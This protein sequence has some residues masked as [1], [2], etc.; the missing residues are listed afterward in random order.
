MHE[1]ILS[2]I[3]GTIDLFKSS[4]HSQL[5]VLQ[6]VTPILTEFLRNSKRDT[7]G[8]PSNQ[9]CD[10]LSH[11][12]KLC[13]APYIGSPPD[14]PLYSPLSG[15]DPLSFSPSLPLCIGKATYRADLLLKKPAPSDFCRKDFN[16]HPSL[17][18]GIFT[19]FCHHGVCYGFQVMETC[20]SPRHPFQ[21]F[22]SRFPATPKVIIY[23]N[24]CKLHQYCLN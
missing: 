11:I 8:R 7:A 23:D 5:L 9:V 3:G 14:Q 6:E 1:A 13:R 22:R 15:N 20:E 21:I 10:V 19:V 18:P 12:V 24:A 2:V 17:L 16:G 4:S